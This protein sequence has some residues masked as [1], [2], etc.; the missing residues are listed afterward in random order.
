MFRD[1]RLIS[2]WRLP[3]CLQ[4]LLALAPDAAGL[5]RATPV[6]PSLPDVTLRVAHGPAQLRPAPPA[7]RG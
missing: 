1:T 5:L 6:P 2:G 4:A 3:S 7:R